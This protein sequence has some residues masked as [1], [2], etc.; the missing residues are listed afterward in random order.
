MSKWFFYQCSLVICVWECI[1]FQ[2]KRFSN[3][4][5]ADSYLVGNYAANDQ[6]TRNEVDEKMHSYSSDV[7]LIN[8]RIQISSSSVSMGAMVIF[9]GLY[10]GIVF[11]ISCAAILALKELS[12]SIDNKGKY[13]IL[14]NVGVE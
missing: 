13:Q 3:F 2:M 8:T 14:R 7:L 1:L 10:I 5:P 9:I 12:Q 11:L 6:D 4:I